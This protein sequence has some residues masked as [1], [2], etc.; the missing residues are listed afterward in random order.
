MEPVFDHTL[1]MDLKLGKFARQYTDKAFINV[2]FSLICNAKEFLTDEQKEDIFIHLVKVNTKQ[3]IYKE[4]SSHR[5]LFHHITHCAGEIST[6]GTMEFDPGEDNVT[7]G[8]VFNS[9]A[10]VSSEFSST[11]PRQ[12]DYQV[13]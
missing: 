10:K 13:F 6:T 1:T 5:E 11:L 7:K 8:G 12:Q 9:T 2:D 4:S 3:D